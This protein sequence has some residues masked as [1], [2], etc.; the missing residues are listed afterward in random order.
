MASPFSIF[1]K[2]QR[3]M[4]AGVTILAMVGFVFIGPWSGRSGSGTGGNAKG[5][6]VATWKFGKIYNSDV[7]R[8]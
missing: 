6:E 2:H 1:R 5:T 3:V 4:L 7:R 8:A